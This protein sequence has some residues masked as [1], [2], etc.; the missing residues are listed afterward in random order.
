MS[1]CEGRSVV[2]LVLRRSIAKKGVG[3]AK[4]PLVAAL[5]LSLHHLAYVSARIAEATS[6]PTT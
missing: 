4:M 2:D 3:L 6:E 5:G 1:N